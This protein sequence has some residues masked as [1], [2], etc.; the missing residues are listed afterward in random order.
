MGLLDR[1][2]AEPEEEEEE[3]DE[4]VQLREA[5]QDLRIQQ[6]QAER[7]AYEVLDSWPTGT[8]RDRELKPEDRRRYIRMANDARQRDP[9]A[10]AAIDLVN[11]FVLGRGIPRPRAR[12]PLVQAELD[13]F[14]DDPDNQLALTSLEAQY[15][16]CTDLTLQCNVFFLEFDDGDDGLLKVGVLDHDTVEAGIRDSENRLRVLYYM[17]KEVTYEWDFEKDKPK[18]RGL[19]E[20]PKVRYYDHWRNVDDA[21]EL[22]EPPPEVP[23]AKQG[24]GRVYH[25]AINR[26]TEEIFGIPTMRRLLRWFSAYNEFMTARVDL[27]KASAAFIMKRKIR[28][29]PNKVQQLAQQVMNRNSELAQRYDEGENVAGPRPASIINENDSLSH[30]PFNLSTGASNAQQDG[31]MLQGQVAAGSH[32]PATYYGANPGSLA[33]ATAVELPVLKFVEARQEV[34][35]STFRHFFDRVIE[36]AQEAG[37]LPY[38]TD[39]ATLGEAEAEEDP[40]DL[41]YEFSLPNPQRRMMGEFVNAIANIAKTFDPNGTNVELSRTLLAL[42]LGQG[43]EVE[44]PADAVKRVFPPGYV[45]PITQAMQAQQAG[46]Q[47]QLFQQPPGQPIGNTPSGQVKDAKN[48]GFPGPNG[49]RHNEQNPYGI[50]REGMQ[51]TLFRDMPDTTKVKAR[52]RDEAMEELFDDEV[53]AAAEESLIELETGLAAGNGNGNGAG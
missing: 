33:G 9:Q 49:D 53:M 42:A 27:M 14:W 28:G 22:G 17:T 37:R 25:V 19:N 8:A 1:F 15:A 46:A 24:E 6:R 26:R 5:V 48:T 29:G 52:Q 44:N 3:L 41:S 7:L 35:E 2:R 18:D 10:G 45:D 32:F 36:R 50:K 31:A 43:L 40:N 21:R 20:K 39:E 47:G 4:T 11:D 34:V 51:E 23:E 16:F 12:N 13:T 38:P 30:E